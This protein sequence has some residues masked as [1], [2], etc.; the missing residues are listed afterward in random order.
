MHC[1]GHD[2]S[3]HANAKAEEVLRTNS[4]DK[5]DNYRLNQL[6]LVYKITVE[7]SGNSTSFIWH[8]DPVLNEGGETSRQNQIRSSIVI[9]S[10]P[11]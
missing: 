2:T 4:L 9:P 1:S 10:T 11:G 5:E 7:A 3:D 6:Q 8:P